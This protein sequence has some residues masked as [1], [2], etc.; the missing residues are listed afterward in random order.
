MT[1]FGGLQWAEDY[2][3]ANVGAGVNT[4]LGAFSADVTQSISQARVSKTSQGQSVRLRYAN[5]L[6]VTNTTLAV[7]GYRYSTEQYRTLQEHVEEL[8]GRI[9]RT[10]TG[11]AKDRIELNVTQS[12]PE[13]S[14]SLS[15]T[16]SDQRYWNL[17]RKSVV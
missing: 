10:V 11:R 13:Q 9:A 6:D 8:D 1:G 7:A 14:G 2:Q 3:A 5:T 17:D 15:L 16:A 12:L 4:G